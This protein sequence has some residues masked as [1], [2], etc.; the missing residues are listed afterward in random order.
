MGRGPYPEISLA[1][2]RA[3][4]TAKAAQRQAQGPSAA[5]GRT[6]REVAEDFIDRNE[7]GWRNAKHRQQSTE[8]VD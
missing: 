5:K 8:S 4:A 3:R 2:A 6:F 7:A 1:E